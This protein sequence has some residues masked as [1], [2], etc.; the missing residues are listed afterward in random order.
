MDLN[1]QLQSR[2]FWKALPVRSKSLAKNERVGK[3][4][5]GKNR[6]YQHKSNPK[7][8]LLPDCPNDRPQST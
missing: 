4:T 7:N 8:Q 1:F 2:P 5:I 6:G 3:Q